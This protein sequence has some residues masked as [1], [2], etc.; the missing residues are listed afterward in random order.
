MPDDPCPLIRAKIAY[1]MASLAVDDAT[2]AV[3]NAQTAKDVAQK[4]VDQTSYYYWLGQ[5]YQYGCESGTGSGSGSGSGLQAMEPVTLRDIV[6][7]KALMMQ[8]HERLLIANEELGVMLD[9]KEE[10]RR[11]LSLFGESD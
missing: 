6:E 1:Y 5:S 2:L 8:F 7:A 3:D 10:A 11:Y 9:M 4:N